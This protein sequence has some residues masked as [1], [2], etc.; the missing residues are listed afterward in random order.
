VNDLIVGCLVKALQ[1]RNLQRAHGLDHL[2]EQ[3]V[4]ATVLSEALP[5]GPQDSED[6]RPIK[7]LPFTM[8][9][10]TH[11]V[12]CLVSIRQPEMRLQRRSV[13]AG[14]L[15]RPGIDDGHVKTL[16]MSRVARRDRGAS[17]LSNSSDQA[18]AKVGGSAS[19][20][21]IGSQ[22]SGGGRSRCVEVQD[23]V[24]EIFFED[25]L[26]GCLESEPPS[27]SWQQG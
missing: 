25:F 23:S 12:L 5:R 22:T 9:A 8:L 19:A 17:R 14:R 20:L 13:D 21:P 1:V 4:S 16:E 6:L 3:F 18:V 15:C 27:A 10:E 11:G 2:T 24:L 7:P 26:E